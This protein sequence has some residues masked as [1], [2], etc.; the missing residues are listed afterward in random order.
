MQPLENVVGSHIFVFAVKVTSLFTVAWLPHGFIYLFYK[1][2]LSGS[3]IS[4]LP[5]KISPYDYKNIRIRL[6][7]PR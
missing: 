2:G 5:V 7:K 4:L 6:L 3:G 1:L